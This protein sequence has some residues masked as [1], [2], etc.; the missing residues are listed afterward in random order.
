MLFS[1]QLLNFLKINDGNLKLRAA[2][3]PL[4]RPGFRD[5]RRLLISFLFHLISIFI[6]LTGR[7]ATEVLNI[8]QAF[9]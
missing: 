9:T 6:L 8:E 7:K 1:Y 2:L 5:T 3:N 4:P